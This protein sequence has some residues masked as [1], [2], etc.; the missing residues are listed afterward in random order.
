MGIDAIIRSLAFA[1]SRT[2]HEA[3][4]TIAQHREELAQALS[5]ARNRGG[6]DIEVKQEAALRDAL[7]QHRTVDKQA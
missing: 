4:M 6:A 2:S 1:E 5:A 7:R 3:M